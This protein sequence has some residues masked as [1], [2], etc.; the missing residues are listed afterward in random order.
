MQPSSNAFPPRLRNDLLTLGISEGS[1]LFPA[2]CM[3]SYDQQLDLADVPTRVM[4]NSKAQVANQAA[5]E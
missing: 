2:L 3:S 5:D 4:S 1:E